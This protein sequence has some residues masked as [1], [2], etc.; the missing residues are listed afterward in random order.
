MPMLEKGQLSVATEMVILIQQ[1]K[2]NNRTSWQKRAGSHQKK[3]DTA[4]RD[5]HKRGGERQQMTAMF[6]VQR[7]LRRVTK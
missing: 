6:A 5:D 4:Q 1:G 2:E 7:I 3:T